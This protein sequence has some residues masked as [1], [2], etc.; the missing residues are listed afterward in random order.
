MRERVLEAGARLVE[1]SH[2]ANVV[3]EI[4][5]GGMGIEH[6]DQHVGHAG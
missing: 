3:I 6:V 1:T 5:S 4:R 2:D